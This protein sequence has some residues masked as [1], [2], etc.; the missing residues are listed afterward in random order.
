MFSKGKNANIK[1]K[2]L[3]WSCLWFL[4][5]SNNVTSNSHR[6]SPKVSMNASGNF[7][8]VWEQKKDIYA[9]YYGKD[10]RRG[11]DVFKVSTTEGANL[12]P[13]VAIDDENTVFIAWENNVSEEIRIYLRHF[14]NGLEPAGEA[15]EIVDKN[16]P[17]NKFRPGVAILNS[18]KLLIVWVDYR[19]KNPDIYGQFYDKY[20]H[21]IG[22]NFKISDD[23]SLVIQS[24]P[25]V[26]AGKDKFVVIWEDHRDPYAFIFGQVI[27]SDGEKIGKNFKVNDS[28]KGSSWQAFASVAVSETGEFVIAWKDY[29]NG[30]SDIYAQKFNQYNQKIGS[31]IRVNDDVGPGW[32]RLPSIAVNQQGNYLIVWEDY[33]N[34][35]MKNQMGDIYA[36]WFDPAL[37]PI[38]ENFK[39]NHSPE[40]S[41]QMTPACSMDIRNRAIIIWED[42]R[43]GQYSNI[44]LQIL[45]NFK[46]LAHDIMVN[47]H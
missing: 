42:H 19:N 11:S 8:L 38:D 24:F 46:L 21:K 4:L 34:D 18:R 45:K 35:S 7:V 39:V 16:A 29:R 44:Y 5:T 12:H 23:T 27:G 14:T 36:Q 26:A 1:I 32:Q 30:D 17:G 31:N 47:N 2:L 41:G 43:S 15:I 28:L 37:N 6:H 40:P 33:R 22:S 25:T 3:F 13:V 9:K 10:I 20:L